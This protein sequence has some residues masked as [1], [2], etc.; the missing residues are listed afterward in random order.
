MTVIYRNNDHNLRKQL[1]EAITLAETAA[2]TSYDNATS[3]LAATDV[4]AAIDE[5]ASASPAPSVKCFVDTNTIITLTTLSNNCKTVEKTSGAD[6]TVQCLSY[7][8]FGDGLGKYYFEVELDVVVEPAK[9]FGVGVCNLQNTPSSGYV[10]ETANSWG[11]WAFGQKYNSG[12]GSG[13]YSTASSGD[14][15]GVAVDTNLGKVWFS[16]NNTWIEGDPAAGTGASYT[17]DRMKGLLRAHFTP[18]VTGS[19]ATLNGLSSELNYAPPTG[20]TAAFG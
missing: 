11:Y 5:L 10:G 14:V 6:N 7:Q 16:K 3:G 13:S 17:S 9:S 19:K 15:I 20:F 2:G 12:V 18:Y 8:V 4:Q 1:S